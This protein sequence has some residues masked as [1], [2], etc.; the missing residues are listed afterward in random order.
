[1]CPLNRGK[2]RCRKR[3]AEF[4]P[5]TAALITAILEEHAMRN[6]RKAQAVVRLAEKY[7]DCIE[8]VAERALLF[9]NTRYKSIKTMLD[10][11]MTEMPT[12]PHVPLSE[13]GKGFLRSPDYF[14]GVA[15]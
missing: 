5:H 8:Q 7:R 14:K 11:G 6:L 13:V 4:G 15:R 10:K 9:G 12:L 1:V 2:I 3:A